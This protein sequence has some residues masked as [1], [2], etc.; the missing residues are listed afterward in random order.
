M[1]ERSPIHALPILP[2]SFLS[3]PQHADCLNHLNL[4]V[5]RH[6]YS[7]LCYLEMGLLLEEGLCVPLAD[8]VS[9]LVFQETTLVVKITL[10]HFSCLLPFQL[11]MEL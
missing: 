6:L 4:G 10:P 2:Q 8:S 1:E 9:L 11:F 3:I 7:S 5:D